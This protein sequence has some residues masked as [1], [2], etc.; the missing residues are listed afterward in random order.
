MFRLKRELTQE[1]R[2]VREEREE[3]VYKRLVI[4]KDTVYILVWLTV[5]ALGMVLCQDLAQNKMR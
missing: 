5:L 3:H 4:I 1:E 2:K